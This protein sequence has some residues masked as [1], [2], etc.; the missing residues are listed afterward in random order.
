MEVRGAG[1]DVPDPSENALRDLRRMLGPAPLKAL[2][3]VVA[4][5]LGQPASQVPS[6]RSI[7]DDM[8]ASS[9]CAGR[10]NVVMPRASFMA[11][12]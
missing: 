7:V 11:A 8:A 10:S 4:G 6:P 1:L 12:S 2:F 5:P 9:G 3:E